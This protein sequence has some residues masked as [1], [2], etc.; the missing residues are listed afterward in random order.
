MDLTEEL[1]HLTKLSQRMKTQASLPATANEHQAAA[2]VS[3]I[4]KVVIE[5]MSVIREQIPILFGSKAKY[6]NI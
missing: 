4:G 1:D 6:S 3:E 2:I 5:I